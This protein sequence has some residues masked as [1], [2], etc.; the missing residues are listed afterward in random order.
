MM[1]SL[2]FSICAWFL[3]ERFDLRWRRTKQCFCDSDSDDEIVGF[4]EETV[5]E[6]RERTNHFDQRLSDGDDDFHLYSATLHATTACS[7]RF[8]AERERNRERKKRFKLV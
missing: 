7:V 2:I 1:F 8:A 4:T 5:Q 3:R 6:A